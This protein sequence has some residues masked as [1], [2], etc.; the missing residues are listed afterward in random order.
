VIRAFGAELDAYAMRTA[1]LRGEGPTRDLQ[2]D[3]VERSFV[4]GFGLE[5]LHQ[6]LR[7]LD[8]SVAECAAPRA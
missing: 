1:G 2:A 8:R 5:Q 3:E 7:D 6:H 4:R